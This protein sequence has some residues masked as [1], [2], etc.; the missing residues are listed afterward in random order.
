MRG[1]NILV[2][3]F[4]TLILFIVAT[5]LIAF[6]LDILT[7]D[8]IIYYLRLHNIKLIAG[9]AGAILIIINYIV[10]RITLANAGGQR[11]VKFKTAE[12]LIAVSLNAIESLTKRLLEQLPEIKYMRPHIFANRRGICVFIK[13]TLYAGPSIPEI[14]KEIQHYIKAKLQETLGAEVNITVKIQVDKIEQANN[15]KAK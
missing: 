9:I 7:L 4:Y 1:F 8:K 15:E 11:S 6:S 10:L 12:G 14:S 5:A 13:T 2:L 3:L